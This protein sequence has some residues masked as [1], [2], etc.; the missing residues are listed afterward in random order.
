MLLKPDNQLQLGD[1][2]L[3]EE[4]VRLLTAN[5]PAAPSNIVRFSSKD[6]GYR[7]EPRSGAS[8]P[9]TILPS[10]AL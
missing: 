10:F 8:L 4:C 9:P 7:Q 5:N 1:K 2:A 6:R 3:A